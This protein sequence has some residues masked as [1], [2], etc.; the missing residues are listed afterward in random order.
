MVRFIIMAVGGPIKYV[1]LFTF[2]Y[3]QIYYQDNIAKIFYILNIYIPL[4]LDLLYSINRCVLFQTKNLHS[5]MVRFI[6]SF[7]HYSD[8]IIARFTFHYGQI[9]YIKKA[10]TK[11]L[12]EKIYIPLWLDLLYAITQSA[13]LI[14]PDLHSTM[15]RFIIQSERY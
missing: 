9:Y 14:N 5:T 10:S 8:I 12:H 6:I 11:I 15:V 7:R 1:N 13:D 4:W 2:H 3:G